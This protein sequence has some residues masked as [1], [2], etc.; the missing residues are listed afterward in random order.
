MAENDEAERKRRHDKEIGMNTELTEKKVAE[1]AQLEDENTQLRDQVSDLQ[2][3]VDKN[4]LLKTQV[5]DLEEE[6]RLLAAENL[7]LSLE[8]DRFKRNFG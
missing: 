4:R 7:R 8:N 5:A 2:E 6:N 3:L 1:I